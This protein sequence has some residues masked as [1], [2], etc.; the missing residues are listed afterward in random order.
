MPLIKY[1]GPSQLYDI[2]AFLFTIQIL[3][4]IFT[5]IQENTFTFFF[6]VIIQ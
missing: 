2:Y 5:I 4:A 6:E 3:N 1:F